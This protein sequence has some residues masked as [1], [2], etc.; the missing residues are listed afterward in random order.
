MDSTGEDREKT[1]RQLHAILEAFI[2]RHGGGSRAID[3]DKWDRESSETDILVV[4]GR[5]VC[6][7]YK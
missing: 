1:I 3:D 6:Y 2:H 5:S 4:D 7:R